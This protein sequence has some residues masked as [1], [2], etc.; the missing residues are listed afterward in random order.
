MGGTFLR[1]LVIIGEHPFVQMKKEVT[2]LYCN[3][4]K[5]KLYILTIIA[6]L[7][8]THGYYNDLL[9]VQPNE[10]YCGNSVDSCALKE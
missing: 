9:D 1:L 3:I 7:L 5:K 6:I 8:S 4:W 10:L 2:L